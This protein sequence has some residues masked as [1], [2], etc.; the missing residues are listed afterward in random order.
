[1]QR[2]LGKTRENVTYRLDDV[3]HMIKC[4]MDVDALNLSSVHLIIR[5]WVTAVSFLP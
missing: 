2:K 4:Q 3:D 1:M 5:Q